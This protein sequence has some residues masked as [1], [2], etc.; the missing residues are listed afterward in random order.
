MASGSYVRCTKTFLHLPDTHNHKPQLEALLRRNAMLSE[1]KQPSCVRDVGGALG[2]RALL[3]D[4]TA[5]G[6]TYIADV[7]LP[8]VPI[9]INS[10]AQWTQSTY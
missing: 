5:H 7:D 1:A 3:P 4:T 6:R 2:P 10:I 9:P 8:S